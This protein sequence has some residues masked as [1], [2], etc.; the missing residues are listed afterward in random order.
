MNFLSMRK[1]YF[2]ILTGIGW[3]IFPQT[4]FTQSVLSPSLFE[5]PQAITSVDGLCSDQVVEIGED[6]QG[7]IWMAAFGGVCRYDGSEVKCFTAGEGPKDLYNSITTDMLIEEDRIW[8]TH[9]RGFSI[10]DL[11]RE[12]FTNYQLTDSGLTDEPQVINQRMFDVYKDRQGE[13]WLSSGRGIIKVDA[14][15]ASMENYP[16]EPQPGDVLPEDLRNINRISVYLQDRFNDSI[17]WVG[18]NGGLL[19]FNK[20]SKRLKRYYF[21]H[22]D[23]SLE[24]NLNRASE[25]IYQHSDGKLFLSTFFAGVN[26]FDPK[27]ES[28]ARL[29]EPGTGFDEVFFDAVKDIRPKSEQELWFTSVKGLMVYHLASQS[30]KLVKQNNENTGTSYGI[31]F[32][33]S[34]GRIWHNTQQGAML[35]DPVVKQVWSSTYQN[36]LQS[37]EKSTTVQA[38]LSQDAQTL[39]LLT[40]EQNGVYQFDLFNGQWNYSK[41]NSAQ[42]KGEKIDWQ[43]MLPYRAGKWL[44]LDQARGLF[45][46]DENQHSLS[47]FPRQPDLE[48][49]AYRSLLVHSSGDLYIGNK[50]GGL[51]RYDHERDTYQYYVTEMGQD[52][53]YISSSYVYDLFE[54]SKGQVWIQRSGGFSV[55]LP[56]QER[57]YHFFNDHK[58]DQS[59]GHIIY[60]GEDQVGR[61]WM[62]STFTGIG[63]AQVAH[64]EQGIVEKISVQQTLTQATLAGDG[65]LWMQTGDG[66]LSFDL[67][68]QETEF[69]GKEYGFD[70]YNTCFLQALPDA[71]VVIGNYNG[72]SLIQPNQLARNQELP[73]PYMTGF[74]VFDQP[75]FADTNLF[76]VSKIN[77]SYQQNFFSIEFSAISHSFPELNSFRYRL[78]NFDTDWIEAQERRFANYT[79]VPGGN[80]V[81]QVQAINNEGLSSEETFEVSI[82]ISTP[83]WKTSW[84]RYGLFILISVIIAVIYRLRL[85]QAIKKER[86]KTEYERKLSQAEL[87]ALRAQMNPHF[88]FNCL[89]S[90]DFYIIKSETRKASEYL[91]QF[92]RLIRLILQ[93]SRAEHISL[94]SELEALGLYMD[95]ERLRFQQRF[96]YE[97]ITDGLPDL[98]MIELPPML[99]QPY[100]EN[101]IWHGL[102]HKQ[103]PGHIA[104]QIWQEDAHLI[105]TIEDNGIGR[106][107]A[108]QLKSRHSGKKKSVGMKI[109]GDRIE[110]IERLYQVSASS[111]IQ[112][113]TDPISGEAQGTRVILSIPLRRR[114][115]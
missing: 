19:K 90:I 10:F 77:L 85:E 2:S 78:K 16:Y 82:F 58:P 51:I 96:T 113:L 52:S 71:Q 73:R 21:T 13:Y 3:L 100:V 112:D 61:V 67:Q 94:H 8:V 46:W 1:V 59:F 20:Y 109:T 91:N 69:F 92:S 105:C 84:A 18:T 35:F 62:A 9:Y 5:N 57:A 79:N 103:E 17:L 101:A 47:P 48:P 36:P 104:I 54:D 114:D 87:Y 15:L 32:I 4:L 41:G 111:E 50:E 30:L 28:F 106:E 33:D 72:L 115:L 26:L 40:Q 98:E 37:K 25:G 39:Y 60:M 65:K 64:P 68:T 81:F 55:F 63:Y 31:S 89:N 56:E 12:T 83:W 86:M 24:G 43:A 110:M 14:G 107:K 45:V 102:M 97:I 74:K 6:S 7:F 80:Y 70:V 44:L 93:N 53:P 49:H 76:E 38:G 95:M 88:I 75:L 34:Q 11:R 99:M 27:T 42:G 29:A 22:Q 108:K 66:L 23:K